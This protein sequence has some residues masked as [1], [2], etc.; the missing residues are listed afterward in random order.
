MYNKFGRIDGP[1]FNYMRRDFRPL[2]CQL[3][4][5]KE[6]FTKFIKRFPYQ[7]REQ[8]YASLSSSGGV[9][10]KIR[11][12]KAKKEILNAEDFFNIASDDE[13]EGNELP[14]TLLTN[15]KKKRIKKSGIFISCQFKRKRK[16]INVC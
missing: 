7:I 5:R 4:I 3:S 16:L 12:G 14:S 1:G 6:G 2:F 8:Y 13:K 9:Q 11:E 10:Q 15:L